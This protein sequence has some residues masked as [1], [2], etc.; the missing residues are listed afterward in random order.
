MGAQGRLVEQADEVDLS[1]EVL[2]L[3]FERDAPKRA[4]WAARRRDTEFVV[5]GAKRA[6]RSVLPHRSALDKA[7]FPSIWKVPARRV[8]WLLRGRW[9]KG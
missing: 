5:P 6:D 2:V 3:K 9:S 1:G 4:Y 8:E 7:D